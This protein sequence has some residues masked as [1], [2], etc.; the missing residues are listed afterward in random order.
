MRYVALMIVMLLATTARAQETIQLR[1][2]VLAPESL[3]AAHPSLI[4]F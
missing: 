1:D 4:A 2:S 3:V